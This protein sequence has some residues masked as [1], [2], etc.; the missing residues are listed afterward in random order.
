MKVLEATHITKI[1]PGV[2][3]LNDVDISI[4][5]GRVHC[6]IG[7]NGA[8]KS[9]LIKTLTGVYVPEE[10]TILI[11][12]KNVHKDKKL[13]E[14]VAYVPQ[15]LDLFK[16]MTVAENLFMPFSRSGFKSAIVNN[17]KLYKSAIPYLKKFQITAKPDDL[18]ANISVS[19]Q[20][21]LQI[22]HAT[23]SETA[24]IIMLDEPTTSLTLKDV[25]RLFEVIKQLKKENKAIIFISHKLDEIFEIGDEITVIRNGEKVGHSEIKDTSVKEIVKQMTGR[26]IDADQTFRPEKISDEILLE[27]ENLTGELF[28]DISFKLHK[29]EILGFSGLVGAGRSEI[30]QAIFGYLPAWKGNVTLDGKPW[31]LGDTNYSANN[32]LIY[33]PEERKQQGILPLL[34]VKENIS[35]PLLSELTNALTIS[36]KKERA[37]AKEVVQTYNIKTPTIEQQI[38]FLSGGNQQ[39]AIIGRAMSCKPKVLIFDEPTK[40]IDVGTKAEIYKIMKRLADEEKIGIILISSELEEILKCSNRVITIYNGKKMGEFDTEKTEKSDIIHS[41]LGIKS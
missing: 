37:L 14:R 26:E 19:E 5:P 33:I 6:I 38:Q 30:M 16:Y 40:G 2:V 34:S 13:F 8:G 17:K 4:E 10:G 3:A 41:I 23:V 27:A 11:D 25:E 36:G 35:V 12:G 1:F 31:K 7:E 28:T 15:E 22:A 24:E 39:K 20:Q 29:G 18:V 9:T 21:L 32:G